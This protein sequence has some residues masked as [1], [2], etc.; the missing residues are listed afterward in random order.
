[1]DPDGLWKPPP[2]ITLWVFH[3]PWTAHLPQHPCAAHR[4]HRPDYWSLFK[5]E[6][7]GTTT[8]P[9][10]KAVRSRVKNRPAISLVNN[11]TLVSETSLR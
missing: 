11:M 8:E 6:G 3:S 4:F 10:T 9:L 5:E 2:R 7:E 1:V